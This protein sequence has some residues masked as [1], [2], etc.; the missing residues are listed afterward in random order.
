MSQLICILVSFLASVIGSICGIGGGVI[1]KP[2]L[3]AWNLYSVSTIS[4]ISGCI[5]LSMSAYSVLE[6][7]LT[8]KS[9]IEKG[10]G[11]QLGIG[12][13]L[14]GV[15]GK[16]LFDI[17]KTCFD[18][19]NT[20]GAIQAAIL[21]AVTFGTVVYTVRRANIHTYR[22]RNPLA[23]LSIGLSLGVIS[24]FLGIGGGPLN[25]T[26]LYFFF[27]MEPKKAAQNSLYIILLSQSASLLVTMLRGAVPAFPVPV[28]LSMVCC[29]ILG[30]ALGRRINRR[31]DDR[32]VNRLFFYL[33]LVIMGICCYNVFRYSS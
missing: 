32:T 31:L 12:A 9:T 2:V 22:I 16:Q 6:A 25:L 19:P 27:S 23:V 29:G 13:A 3:D 15:L 5:V 26:V 7:K 4:F 10:S 1:I 24:A 20:I 17:A 33:L 21:F 18:D 14:G 8:H 28:F 30:G 11:T